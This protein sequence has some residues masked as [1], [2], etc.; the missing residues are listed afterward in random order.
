MT[1]Q[2]KTL[3]HLGVYGIILNQKDEILLIKKARGPYTG[4]LDLPGGSPD[5]HETLEE[6]LDREILEETGLIVQTRQQ[7]ITLLALFPYQDSLLRHIGIIYNVQIQSQN[8]L[9]QD[10]DGEDS[11]G[12]LWFPCSAVTTSNSAPLVVQ[13]KEKGLI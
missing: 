10:T 2:S 3:F 5:N 11:H 1:T 4:L 8:N 12:A 13:L 6:T 9:K 7:A